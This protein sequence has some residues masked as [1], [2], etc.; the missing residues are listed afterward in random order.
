MA[1]TTAQ[2]D[3]TK[4]ELKFCAN[5]NPVRGVSE[6]RS[7]EGLWK[8]SRLEIRLKAFRQ[9]TNPQKQL[10]IIIIGTKTNTNVKLTV[11]LKKPRRDN[12]KTKKSESSYLSN[13]LFKLY[14][15][16][17][18]TIYFLLWVP[19]K[20]LITYSWVEYKWPK[21]ITNKIYFGVPLAANW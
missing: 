7:N 9:S 13:I 12:M 20:C 2:L 8:R 14:A 16:F 6:I 11:K 5:S 15:F 18:F 17:L 3:S 4:P 10:I 1:V 21:P 19:L